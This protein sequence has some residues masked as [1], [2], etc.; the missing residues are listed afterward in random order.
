VR[1]N[2]PYCYGS[3]VSEP[4]IAGSQPSVCALADC[5]VA[6]V[7]PAGGG[8]HRLYCSDA[9]R[10][11]AR[12][13][14]LAGSPEVAPPDVVASALARLS[15]VVEDLRSHETVLRSV[16]PNR[17]A[18]DAARIRAE[19]TSEVLAAQRV[20]S[21][22]TQ[23]AAGAAERHAAELTEWEEAR[24]RHQ[25]ETEEL[26]TALAG[27]RERSKSLQD[28][29]DAAVAAHRSELIASDELAARV[30][31]AHEE[32]TRGLQQQLD[33]SKTDAA[34]AW[35]RADAADQ[36]AATAEATARQAAEHA[37]RSEATAGE[38]RVDLA[39]AQAA[40]ESATAR[41][42]GAERLLEDA[43]AELVIERRR[44]DVSLSQLHDQ[45]DE[46]IAQR[47][48]RQTPEKT[49]TRKRQ[50]VP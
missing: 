29:L 23:D 49:S 21:Q 12:R 34:A 38:L 33:Q 5:D 2:E 9:H 10:A 18:V 28:A 11:E 8:R 50:S 15:A 14:R 27:A 7:Q 26:R 4:I 19:A 40:A 43:R 39:R 47:P 3:V 17:Q 16:D 31:V 44:H 30:A 1:S 37:A 45:L 36:R 20:A 25:V 13:R 41:S 32:Q 24:S 46:L 48:V 6:V 42:D 35:A 22:A